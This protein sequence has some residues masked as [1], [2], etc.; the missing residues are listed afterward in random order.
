MRTFRYILIVLCIFSAKYAFGQVNNDNGRR[1]THDFRIPLTKDS[2]IDANIVPLLKAYLAAYANLFPYVT[3]VS[4]TEPL[5]ETTHVCGNNQNPPVPCDPS[6]VQNVKDL[7]VDAIPVKP[8]PKPIP[9]PK[10]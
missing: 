7:D 2:E 4:A 5:I 10:P 9:T 1:F 6:T 8:T 3:A